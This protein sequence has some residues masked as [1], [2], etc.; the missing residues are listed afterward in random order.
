MIDRVSC[1]N[2]RGSRAYNND[3]LCITFVYNVFV[4]SICEMENTSCIYSYFLFFF[5][6]SNKNK[7]N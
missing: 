1:V 3:R 6:S 7:L 5:V 4:Y 2:P